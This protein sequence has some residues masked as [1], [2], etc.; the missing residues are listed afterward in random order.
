[1]TGCLLTRMVRSEQDG[2]LVRLLGCG[3]GGVEVI[4]AEFAGSMSI[5]DWRASGPAAAERIRTGS[6]ATN[7][8]GTR[9]TSA[10][11]RGA[12]KSEYTTM[13]VESL[14]SRRDHD[15]EGAS[16]MT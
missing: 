16:L 15:N 11:E 12:T 1:M 10:R 4:S 3:G 5:V 8:A 7:D 14:A 6:G 2:L 13:R 9:E